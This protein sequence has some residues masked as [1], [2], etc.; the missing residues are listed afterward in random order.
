MQHPHLDETIAILRDLIAFPS[1]SSESNLALIDY[2]AEKL[3]AAGAEVEVQIEPE[4][5]TKANLFARIGPD[6]PG[7]IVLSGHSDVVPV[8]DQ[9]WSGDPF[10]MWEADGKLYGRGS[11]DMKGFI[12]AAVA[13]APQ[14]AAAKHGT[15]IYYA[16]TYDEETGCLGAQHLVAALKARPVRPSMV[17]VGE[18]TEM[19]VIEGHKGCFEYTTH[20]TG[21][22]G[23]GSAP[24]LGVNAV[25][26][27]ARYVMHLMELREA[28]KAR[29]PKSSPFDPPWT[30]L[31]IGALHGGSAHNVIAPTAQVEWEMRPIQPN[32]ANFVKAK[33]QSFIDETLLP[34]MQARFAGAEIM[35]ETIGEIAGLIPMEENAIRD[36]V[37][38]LTGSNRS[39]LVAFGTEAGL[40]QDLGM[41]V[42]V[43]G[44]GSIAQ[45]HKADEFIEISQL[46]SCLD[47]LTRLSERLSG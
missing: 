45:A 29:A 13:L 36:M 26:Y 25:E 33:M 15:P 16:F 14:F 28:L 30:T 20:F 17:I 41:D 18:P 22:P 31:N 44:P 38:A 10:E 12:A 23:H 6:V 39:E 4:A 46:E 47:L 43:C 2:L 9:A 11:C 3:R 42:I 37:M 40:F 19:R 21:L 35:T 1:V 34:Q 32:D 8:T 24:D 7:G 27:A 5:G